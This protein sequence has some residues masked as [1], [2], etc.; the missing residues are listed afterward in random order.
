MKK[1]VGFSLAG[2]G[3]YWLLAAILAAGAALYWFSGLHPSSM[4][5]WMPWDFSCLEYLA[6]ALTLLWLFRGL[7]RTPVP[8]RLPVWRRFSFCLGLGLIYAVLQTHFDYMAQHMFFVNRIQHVMMHHIGPFFIA[9]GNAGGTIRRGLPRPVRR[10]T[11]NRFVAAL[12]RTLQNPVLAVILF[13]GLFYFWL[14]PPIHFRAMLDG[15]LY[16]LMNWSMVL[17]GI[18]FW[19]LV[20]DPRPKPPARVSYGVRVALSA[21][22][23]FPQILLGAAIVF[24]QHDIYPYYALCGRIFPSITPLDDQA[25]GGIVSW[26]PPGMM[27]A[28]ALILVVN[29]LR[30]HEENDRRND[31][32]ACPLPLS[33]SDR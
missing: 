28:I 17:D 18:L 21:I 29:A 20:L 12:I 1:E 31:Y 14:I 26:I 7:N 23:M 19:T 5:A 24:S 16:A 32:D 22:V 9:L 33:S 6:T 11:D 10:I 13:V 4:P 15:R 2:P 30:L 27:S 3:H 8:Q 25:L